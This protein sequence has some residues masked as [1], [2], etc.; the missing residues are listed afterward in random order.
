MRDARHHG[1]MMEL[2]AEMRLLDV[3][4]HQRGWSEAST[5]DWADSGEWDEEVCGFVVFIIVF[6]THTEG[7]ICLLCSNCNERAFVTS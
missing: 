2:E 1:S 5:W 4:K 3:P 7:R 6:V